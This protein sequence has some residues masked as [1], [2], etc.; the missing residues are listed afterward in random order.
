MT[1]TDAAVLRVQ[2]DDP[3]YLANAEAEAAFWARPHPFGVGAPN[4]AYADGPF[5]RYTNRR[6]TGDEH[7]RWFETLGRYGAFRNA[8]M[9]GAASVDVESRILEMH[10]GL[11]MTVCDISEGA[12][13]THAAALNARFPGRV[14]TRVMDLNFAELP[15]AAYDVCVSTA[16]LHHITNLEWLASQVQRALTPGA[17][18][19]L[20]DY[21]GEA[22]FHF[23]APKRQVFEA[24]LRRDVAERP[25]RASWTIDWPEDSDH[26]YS[27]FEAI[28]A[29]ETLNI[30]AARFQTVR[31]ATAGALTAL[32]IFRRRPAGWR[33]P[34]GLR[35]ALRR[36]TD[37]RAAARLQ[38]F[39]RDVMLLDAVTCDSGLLLP[40][41]AFAVFRKQA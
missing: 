14:E 39:Q 5:D 32:Y 10:P 21:V 34:A 28:R 12:I 26:E 37:P 29:D 30:L 11:R 15:P 25:E 4:A 41:N 18:I 6:F 1:A 27:P 38:R 24:L 35:R 7:V 33:E 22:R 2:R 16:T 17:H 23:T 40:N 13:E 36:L 3:G 8:L 19:L 20:Q 31:V 9:L